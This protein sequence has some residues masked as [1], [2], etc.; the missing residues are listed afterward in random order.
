MAAE[1]I[2]L[3]RLCYSTFYANAVSVYEFLFN[4]S[5]VGGVD[6]PV[7][8]FVTLGLLLM[9]GV[10]V[11]KLRKGFKFFFF[12][13]HT[14]TSVSIFLY[15]MSHLKHIKWYEILLPGMQRRL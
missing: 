6:V 10:F 8:V 13:V 1:K 11:V 5:V 12:C 14:G 15:Y 3:F 9:A 2:I 4:R 7:F